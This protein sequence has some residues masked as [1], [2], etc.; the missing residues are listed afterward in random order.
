[1]IN[2]ERA[3]A[4]T[5]AGPSLSSYLVFIVKEHKLVATFPRVHYKE[6]YSTGSVLRTI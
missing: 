3:Q 4:D 5:Y 2:H 1:M 6:H